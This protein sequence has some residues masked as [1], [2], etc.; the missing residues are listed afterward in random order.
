MFRL[1]KRLSRG[2]VTRRISYPITKFPR[3]LSTDVLKAS[4]GST[5]SPAPAENRLKL[6]A[7]QEECIQSVISHL[8]KGYKRL[9]ISLATGSGKTV[10]A[11]LFF[12]LLRGI[13][14]YLQVIFTQ[15]I[16]R[17]QPTHRHGTRTLIL[18]HRR[19][20]VDQAAM[21]CGLA[22]PDKS[23]EIEMGSLHASGTADI[24]VASVQSLCSGSRLSKFDPELYK[25]VLVDEA[26]HVVASQY[27]E[28]LDHFGLK[29]GENLPPQNRSPVLVGVSATFSRFDG[30]ALGQ[31]ID[32]IVYHKDYVEMIGEKW[33][34]NVMFTT[35]ESR[36]DIRGVRSG[37]NGDFQTNALSKAVNTD[38]TNEIT[39][40][41]WMKK[42]A[43]RKSTLVFAV[44]VNHVTSLAAM[45]RKFGY[46]AR[47]VTGNT[48]KK[49]RSERVDAFR[50]GQFPVLLNCGVFTEGTDIPNID[51]V[52]LA[53]PTRS[54]NLLVQMIGRGMRLHTGKENCHIIDMVAALN[55]G[56][57]S[58]P[59]LFGL[60]PAAIVESATVSDLES[61]RN[62]KERESQRDQEAAAQQNKSYAGSRGLLNHEITFTDYDSV[63][64]LI[65]DTVEERA[66]RQLSPFAWVGVG[67]DRYILSSR[68]GSYLT[69][70]TKQESFIVKYTP[71]LPPGI[72]SRVPYGRPRQL[73]Q[74][75]TFEHAVHAADTF[76]GQEFEYGFVGKH[77]SWRRQ[78]ASEK[79]LMFLN[80]LRDANDQLTPET[81][82]KG[83]AYDMITKIKHG[84]R[85]RYEKM[86]AQKRS[87]EKSLLKEEQSRQRA[88]RERVQ[89]G[90]LN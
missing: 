17:I 49:V 72:Q 25:L 64:D 29:D 53:R 86:G 52:L 71:K 36:A 22:Y 87:A 47:F 59:T 28:I 82:T 89:V 75:D 8:D 62:T 1:L 55:T 32:H 61:L 12:P 50:K 73:A 76:A 68:G 80:K 48:P 21:H 3:C 16:D 11:C 56:I 57:I 79:Q 67:D 20:L 51:C 44:G 77:Q 69:I 85:G 38:E 63:N 2:Y 18:A 90:P 46:D 40:R 33:L 88:E 83:K 74:V 13:L 45:F 60:D 9:G 27:L 19:E 70:E 30:R 14:T 78:P 5:S 66:I 43:T 34:A 54:R 65:E 81:C 24:T 4:H 41:A 15:L 7:Y 37:P 6:R 31:V 35:V 39:V 58:T 26:H 42:A 23:I 10:S 84:A